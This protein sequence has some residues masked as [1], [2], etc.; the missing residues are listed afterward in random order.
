MKLLDKINYFIDKLS[1]NPLCEEEPDI[2]V[3]ELVDVL[4]IL[5]YKVYCLKCSKEHD[6]TCINCSIEQHL[7]ELEDRVYELEKFIKKII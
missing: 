6:F 3:H 5:K 7:V 1:Y 4:K 2:D